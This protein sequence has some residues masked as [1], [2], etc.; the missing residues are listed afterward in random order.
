MNNMNNLN[1][2]EKLVKAEAICRMYAKHKLSL[3][4][5]ICVI[6]TLVTPKFIH[7]LAVIPYPGKDFFQTI[8][9]SLLPYTNNFA[10]LYYTSPN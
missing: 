2:H 9:I 3:L 6:K 1:L 7:A 4:G 5:K 8:L 10:T